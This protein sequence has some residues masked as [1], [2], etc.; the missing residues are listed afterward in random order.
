MKEEEKEMGTGPQVYG[1]MYTVERSGSASSEFQSHVMPAFSR[2]PKI[3]DHLIPHGSNKVSLK[4]C[5][6]F[7]WQ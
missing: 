4:G 7:S 6:L 1:V 3:N 2:K 5:C